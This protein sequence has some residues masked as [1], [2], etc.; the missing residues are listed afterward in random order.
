MKLRLIILFV[1]LF[2]FSCKVTDNTHKYYDEALNLHS[3][4][5]YD[6]CLVKLHLLVNTYPNSYYI[7]NAYYLISEIYLNEFKEYDISILYLNKVLNLFPEHELS[8]KCLF[9]LAYINANYIDSFTDAI[10]LYNQFLL[11][12]PNDDLIPSV[13]YELENLLVIKNKIDSLIDS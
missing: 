11:K 10:N 6:Q 9:T 12:Y 1:S 13:K 8:K 2:A 7:P 4:G 3:N 5:E